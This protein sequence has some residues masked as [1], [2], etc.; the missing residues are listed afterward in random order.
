MDTIQTVNQL[1]P[2]Q[3]KLIAMEFLVD[4]RKSLGVFKTMDIEQLTALRDRLADVLAIKVEEA[5]QRALA[6]RAEKTV[7]EDAV[8]KTMA[9]LES[10]GLKFNR[11]QIAKLLVDNVKS[12]PKSVRVSSGA[13][14]AETVHISS[15]GHDAK[16]AL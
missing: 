13:E 1:K 16:H 12:S 7:I 8:N 5:E 14:P 10:Q 2:A 3:Q 6:E 9:H 11:Q 15:I 4:K